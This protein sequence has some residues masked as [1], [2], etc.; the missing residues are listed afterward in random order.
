MPRARALIPYAT[1]IALA[2]IVFVVAAPARFL[3]YDTQYALLW[4]DDLVHGRTPDYDVP[5]AP[6]PHPLA[7]LVGLLGSEDVFIVLAFLALGDKV[8]ELMRGALPEGATLDVVSGHRAEPAL[9]PVDTPAIA[10]AA[11]RDQ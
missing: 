4:G 5:F 9:F 3:N 6:T 8:L 7:T 11:L 1:S 2:A 10:L